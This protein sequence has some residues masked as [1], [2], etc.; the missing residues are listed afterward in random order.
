MRNMLSFDGFYRV[1]RKKENGFL[2][3]F[4]ELYGYLVPRGVVIMSTRITTP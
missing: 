2:A 4:I 1:S 3:V